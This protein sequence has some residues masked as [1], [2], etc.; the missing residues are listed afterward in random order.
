MNGFTAL[1]QASFSNIP[2]SAKITELLVKAGVDLDI[3][4]KFGRSAVDECVLS[5]NMD[6][7]KVLVTAGAKT[8][9]TLRQARAMGRADKAKA[10]MI[11]YLESVSEESVELKTREDERNALLMRLEELERKEQEEI[12][13]KRKQIKKLLDKEKTRINNHIEKLKKKKARLSEELS[14]F[15]KEGDKKI[16][17]LV[18]EMRELEFQL[19]K[20]K[21]RRLSEDELV[22]CLECP[23][24]LGPCRKQV[25]LFA[26]YN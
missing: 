23:V 18:Q 16:T 1:H 25:R 15:K 11:A 10:G 12:E 20:K 21:T 8:E 2:D 4:N 3:K 9:S 17:M 14:K 7:L 13:E 22:K 26:K 24:C 6:S 19:I 5:V